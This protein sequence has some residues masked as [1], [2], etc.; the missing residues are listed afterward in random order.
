MQT[1]SVETPLGFATPAKQPAH[2]GRSHT[3]VHKDY[4]R[5]MSSER[6]V[7]KHISEKK[8]KALGKCQPEPLIKQRA[9]KY[10]DVNEALLK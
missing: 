9:Y 1:S 3:I 2:L 4:Y 8:N 6:K 5:L 7:D 10:L